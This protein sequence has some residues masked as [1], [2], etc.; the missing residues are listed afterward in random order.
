[1]V[2]PLTADSTKI[3]VL[4][5]PGYLKFHPEKR[6]MVPTYPP[7]WP[8]N[9]SAPRAPI[10]TLAEALTETF[11]GEKPNMR[12]HQ[13]GRC[14]LM[15]CAPH[16]LK[17][18]ADSAPRLAGKAWEKTPIAM[19]LLLTDVDAS[20]KKEPGFDS[21]AW[22]SAQAAAIEAFLDNHPGAFVASSRGGLRIYQ[23]LAQPFII[24]SQQRATE[25]KQRYTAWAGHVRGFP[26]V[27][28]AQGGADD[29]KDWTRLQRIPHDTRDGV[30]QMLPTIG[31]PLNVGTVELPGPAPDPKPRTAVRPYNGPVCQARI[32]RWVVEA[33]AAAL[34]R[35]G[36][37]VHDAA[38]ALG[39]LM[40]ASRW[41]T[42]DCVGFIVTCF[43]FAGIVREDIARTAQLSVETARAGGKTYGWR[44]FIDLCHGDGPGVC[45]LLREKVPGLDAT[46][47]HLDAVEAS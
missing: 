34:P 12:W 1:M 4:L 20:G 40:S 3:E 5:V 47:T 10:V 37:G 24:D 23:V 41:S 31:D 22:W 45:T 29:L 2:H 25:W 7:S 13:D 38:F 28:A 35:Q 16:R 19:Q 43:E 39:G 46:S 15:Q 33:V 30:L 26:W 17:S 14:Y 27:N 11:E 36:D 32:A 21:G 42:E 6:I 9:K 18:G 44:R 8:A